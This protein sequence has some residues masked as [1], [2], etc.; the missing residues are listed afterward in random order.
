MEFKLGK[1][2]TGHERDE[3]NEKDIRLKNKRSSWCQ[4]YR[5]L[6]T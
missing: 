6:G 5:S 1:R 4:N 3:G 2:K